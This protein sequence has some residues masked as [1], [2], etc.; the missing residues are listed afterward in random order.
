MEDHKEEEDH[1]TE[2]H[3]KDYP[4]N[5][6]VGYYGWLTLDPRIIMPPWYLLVVV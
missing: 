4:P 6:H 2:T 3:L 5:P 1:L